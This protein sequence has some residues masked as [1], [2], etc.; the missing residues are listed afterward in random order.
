ML[1]DQLKPEVVHSDWKPWRTIILGQYANNQALLN[2]LRKAECAGYLWTDDI[3]SKL[4][5]RPEPRSKELFLVS[6]RDLGITYGCDYPDL[7]TIAMEAGFRVAPTETV[8]Q[9]RLD[10]NDQPLDERIHIGTV[11]FPFKGRQRAI[12]CLTH[13]KQGKQI[14]VREPG[15][16]YHPDE[17]FVF[18]R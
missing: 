2:A 8:G 16:Y 12:F 3:V 10:Y 11:T 4:Q 15:E 13:P 6:L 1:F 17:K 7:R 5:V 9:L 18:C 14:M